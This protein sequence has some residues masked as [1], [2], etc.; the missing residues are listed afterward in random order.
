VTNRPVQG[1]YM[2]APPEAPH[3]SDLVSRFALGIKNYV[4]PLGLQRLGLPCPLF[5]SGMAFP[6]DLL[7]RVP[8][9]SADLVED[10]RLGLHLCK[11]DRGA[12][13][14]PEAHFEGELPADARDAARQRR[15][16]EHGH[17]GLLVSAVRLALR[18]LIRGNPR[19][20]AAGLDH[21]VQPLTFLTGAILLVGL[22]C[23]IRLAVAPASGLAVAQAVLATG[24][25]ALLVGSLA[26]AWAFQ[27][28]R[29]VPASSLLGL[30][31]YLFRRVPNQLGFLYRRQ[32]DWVRTPREGE[33]EVAERRA[34]MMP[35]ETAGPRTE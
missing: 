14:C 24:T 13:F 26:V 19:M 35:V 4:R 20:V 27:L 29:D 1:R 32:R 21:A 12:R 10:M 8:L 28:R 5:G 18:G 11:L 25:F 2:M 33:R 3:R 30:P 17:L 15:R 34:A 16:W 9:A 31:T 6:T 22:F 7:R 23:L